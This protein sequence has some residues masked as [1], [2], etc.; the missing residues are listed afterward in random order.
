MNKNYVELN[1]ELVIVTNDDGEISIRRNFENIKEILTKENKMELL[2]E[3]KEL[4][5]I[6][7]NKKKDL[8]KDIYFASKAS[9]FVFILSALLIGAYDLFFACLLIILSL[10]VLIAMD[11]VSKV[12]SRKLLVSECQIEAIGEMIEELKNKKITEKK[13]TQ[14]KRVNGGRVYSI[15]IEDMENDFLEE[16]QNKQDNIKVKKR[17]LY[18]DDR[19]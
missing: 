8:L 14:N 6:Y 1:N 9:T 4:F 19:K 3:Y 16:L 17:V 10:P 18:K 13:I 5:E 2:Y 11:V 15:D 12:I 7:F